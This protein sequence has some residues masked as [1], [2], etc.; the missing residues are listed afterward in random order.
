MTI[1][2]RVYVS[3]DTFLGEIPIFLVKIVKQMLLH[4][5]CCGCSLQ[6][7]YSISMVEQ[8]PAKIDR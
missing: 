1:H 7:W 2:D 5:Y 4:D 6:A 8:K 3:G